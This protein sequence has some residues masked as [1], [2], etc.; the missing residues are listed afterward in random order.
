FIG[1]TREDDETAP[2]ARVLAT[3]DGDSAI[4]EFNG[5]ELYV[6]A[7]VTSSRLH[8]RPYRK[9]DFEMAWTQP[10]RPRGLR[11]ATTT[12]TTTDP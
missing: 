10:V 11:P 4:Y 2:T 7:R 5:D 9:G 6:R 8:P 12:T 1:A 3:V